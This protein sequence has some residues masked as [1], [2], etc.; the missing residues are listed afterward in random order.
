[1]QLSI[2][3]KRIGK[4]IGQIRLIC[5]ILFMYVILYYLLL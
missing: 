3:W 1:M 5:P 4:K 2:N